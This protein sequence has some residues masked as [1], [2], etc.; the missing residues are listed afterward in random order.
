M[1]NNQKFTNPPEALGKLAE[2]HPKYHDSVVNARKRDKEMVAIKKAMKAEVVA[3]L[4]ELDAY[5]TQCLAMEMRPCLLAAVST[6]RVKIWKHH[7][8]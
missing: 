1:V 5:V 4:T 2:L 7:C 8:R 6:S 3:L